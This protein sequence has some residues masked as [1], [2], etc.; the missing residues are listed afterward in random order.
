MRARKPQM[1]RP[2]RTLNPLPLQDLEPHRFEDLIRQLAYDFR[3]WR[4]LE[5]I[6]RSGSDDGIDIRG[7]E[8]G[9]SLFEPEDIEGD[10][11]REPEPALPDHDRLWVFQC[12]RERSIG[13]KKVESI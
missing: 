7:V 8:Q 12:K 3:K 4:S 9:A 1:A 5:A 2:T 11:T 10:D 13:P 6:G